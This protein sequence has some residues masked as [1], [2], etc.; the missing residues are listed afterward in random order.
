MC[1]RYAQ[2]KSQDPMRQVSRDVLVEDEELIDAA[3]TSRPNPV[4][5]PTMPRRS[6]AAVKDGIGL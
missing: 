6:F 1:N 2:T 4:S 5:S 3:G